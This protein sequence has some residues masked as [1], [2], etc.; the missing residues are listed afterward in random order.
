MEK[1]KLRTIEIEYRNWLIFAVILFIL[2]ILFPIAVLI[3]VYEFK[4][5]ISVFTAF[6]LV[7]LWWWF[8][9][10]FGYL[11]FFSR[12]LLSR[13]RL[14][15][16]LFWLMYLWPLLIVILATIDNVSNLWITKTLFTS[17]SSVP[18]ILS[19]IVAL[20]V[21]VLP[22]LVDKL[23]SFLNKVDV[24]T[25]WTT[26][27]RVIAPGFGERIY[28]SPKIL[29]KGLPIVITNR[30]KRAVVVSHIFL[31]IATTNVPLNFKTK[32]GKTAIDYEEIWTLPEWVVVQSES[33]QILYIPWKKVVKASIRAQEITQR[34]GK[35]P[36]FHV[37]IYDP[38]P[39]RQ[40]WSKQIN[41]LALMGQF[42]H[43]DWMKK[44]P[45]WGKE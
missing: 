45:D 35:R 36:R 17:V 24:N 22:L 33:S 37:G 34:V 13:P 41:H 1:K 32:S 2:A 39:N 19:S 12:R 8:P 27:E 30:T 21:A 6:F 14:M 31:G 42:S 16:R 5:E 29:R 20:T 44:H 38:F 26:R 9:A 15:K 4:S 23:S 43:L 18:G 28:D 40:S 7:H 3:I 11:P 25:L 10:K